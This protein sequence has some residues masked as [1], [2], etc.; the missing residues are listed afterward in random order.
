MSQTFS[1]LTILCIACSFKGTE[2]MQEAHRLGCKIYLVTA[3]KLDKK[4]WP[5]EILADVFY[6]EE[7]EDVW[8]IPNLVKGI[9]Y[10]ARSIHF[11]RI[12]PLDDYDLEKASHLREHL[13]VAGMGD[14][15]VRYFRDKLAM[16]AKAAEDGIDVPEFV[17]ILNYD[18][19][20]AFCSIVPP[21]WVLKPRSQ[22]SATG[23]L[24]INTMEQLWGEI[25][26]LGDDQSHY[27]L[28]RYVPG[29]IF[30]VD[31]IVYDNKV[32]FSRAH[33]Y[34]KPPMDV[35]AGGIFST[36]SVEYASEEEKQLLEI[37]K[38]VSASMGL[39]HG[40]T[41]T[42]FIRSYEDG[43]Y[44]FLE[45]SARV[46]GAH[47]AEMVEASSGI[48]LWREWARIEALAPESKYNVPNPES[49]YSCIIICLARQQFPDTSHYNDSEV[50]WRLQMDYHAGLILRSDSLERLQ[51]LQ[52]SYVR[53][54]SKD[55]AKH[56]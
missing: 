29:D 10:L 4:P 35:V 55:F 25:D 42:E 9:S 36:S 13:R 50:V 26:A 16:R 24:K 18:R 52:Q 7:D 31:S 12:V 33:K 20:R 23:I 46:G 30:H 56:N 3:K 37:N 8:N 17:H 48:N 39:L 2:F 51:E 1:P 45:T 43:R 53:R 38:R 54:F 40:V 47:I 5:R 21:P 15:R 32:V 19:I 41:H 22:A 44:Y 27:L 11:D 49:H 34:G 6:V 28:E 14:T